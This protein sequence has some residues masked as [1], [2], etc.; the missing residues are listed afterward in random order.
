M[1]AQWRSQQVAEIE[2]YFDVA[3][4]FALILGFL[5]VAILIVLPRFQ[6]A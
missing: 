4:M 6:L 2:L 3:A 1:E 5:L